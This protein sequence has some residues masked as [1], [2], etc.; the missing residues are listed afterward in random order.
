MSY[1]IL[2]LFTMCNKQGMQRM[3]IKQ[4]RNAVQRE[5]TY[6]SDQCPLLGLVHRLFLGH[7]HGNFQVKLHL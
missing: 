6:I 7:L 3:V 1:F 4:I 5:L 2:H